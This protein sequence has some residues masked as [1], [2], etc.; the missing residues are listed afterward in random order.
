MSLYGAFDSTKHFEELDDPI[1]TQEGVLSSAT[2]KARAVAN[3][4]SGAAPTLTG[5]L[6]FVR[7]DSTTGTSRP[8]GFTMTNTGVGASMDG[9]WFGVATEV[10]LGTYANAINGKLDFGTA[11]RVTG[12]GGV[13]CGELDLGAGTTQ[14]TYAVFEGELNIPTGASL[15]TQ[16][17]FMIFNAWGADVAT[18]DTS[19]YLMAV[20][21]LSAGSGKL[22]Q[23]GNTFATPAATL[24]VKIG[25]TDYYLPL[26]NGQITTV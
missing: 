1:V 3:L 21:G 4:M 23:T 9:A 14:G 22:L 18:F 8:L 24:K 7:S 13:I 11:G 25:A 5:D 12:L 16:T 19:G 10:A 17:S 15:G 20:T 2:R 6:D 26:Y